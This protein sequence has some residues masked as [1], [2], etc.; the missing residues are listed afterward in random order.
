VVS[1]GSRR[2]GIRLGIRFGWLFLAAVLLLGVAWLTI[3]GL[4][5]KKQVDAAQRAVGQIRISVDSG[6][7][8]S[9]SRQ[10][11]LLAGHAHRAHQLTTGP[12]WWL[13]AQLP[14]LG[15]PAVAVRGD[16][17]QLDGLS[18]GVLR[19]LLDVAGQLTA[20]DLFDH[21]TVRLPPLV[22]A[23]PVIDRARLHL[24]TTSATVQALPTD[25]WLAPVNRGTA[26]F[27][28]QLADLQGQLDTVGRA[29]DLLPKLLGG[30][31]QQRY[32]VGLENEA[33]SR[34]LGGIPG[35]FAIVTADH[36][37]IRF[38]RFESDTTLQKVRTGLQLGPD[39]QQRYAA[40]D[41]ANNYA[42]S[43]IGPDFADAAQIWAA[44][45]QRYSG[46]RVDGAIA[47]DPTAISYLLAV[48]GPASAAGGEPI[49]AANVVP[50]TQ[51]T[52]YQRYPNTAQR[53]AFLIDIATGISRRLLSTHGST[54]LIRAGLKG[55]DQR[56]LLFW[57]ADAGIE[58]Q[59][60][61]SALTGG[62]DAGQQPFVGFTTVNATGGKLDY[63]LHRSLDYRR[64]ACGGQLVSTATITLTNSV[65]AGRLPDYVTLRAD[66]PGYP[67]R[68]GDN[69]V[70]L[71][72][73]LTPGSR[74]TA[75]A[76]DGRPTIVAPGSENGLT[77]FTLPVELPAG[78]SRVLTVTA[79]EP[80]RSGAVRVLKQPA[81]NPVSVSLHEQ[82]C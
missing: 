81:V 60:R 7:I 20:G 54:Q 4:L 34:G 47:I 50:L 17:A 16:A 51:K 71:N 62:L 22:A 36:G 39:Y 28:S 14:W 5:A 42:N 69:K 61:S 24:T 49:T 33:E 73:Y 82:G 45:W 75:V 19:P 43:T 53:K 56:R 10:A 78:A 48:T 44:M 6:D 30:N 23:A 72:Y 79:T 8:D 3:T 52:L 55:A 77:V 57:S 67:T 12:S 31:G 26:S 80:S 68:P 74:I 46:E 21:G 41:P 66:R 35:A 37:Q 65:P 29:T 11:Q 32:F 64:K 27:R 58:S 18:P 13:A 1:G 25:T 40:A 59:L 38:E 15:R 76:L 70:L 63:Y 9:A 2:T